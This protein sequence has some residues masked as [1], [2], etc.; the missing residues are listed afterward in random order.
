M[1]R[2]MDRKG[3]LLMTVLC[4]SGKGFLSAEEE[5]T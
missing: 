5:Q 1:G 3:Q 2:C 4:A